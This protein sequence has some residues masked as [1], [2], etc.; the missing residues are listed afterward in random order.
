MEF[1]GMINSLNSEFS[2]ISKHSKFSENSIQFDRVVACQLEFSRIPNFSSSW[3]SKFLNSKFLNSKFLKFSRIPNSWNS[4]NSKFLEFFEQSSALSTTATG[5]TQHHQSHHVTKRHSAS[6]STAPQYL[7]Q[8]HQALT[9]T[10]PLR[11][12]SYCNPNLSLPACRFQAAATS[13]SLTFLLPRATVTA[14]LQVCTPTM[15][16][17]PAVTPPHTAR[18]CRVHAPRR[19]FMARLAASSQL[20]A[21][22]CCR[23]R[24]P[25]RRPVRDTACS[26]PSLPQKNMQQASARAACVVSG[27]F[28]AASQLLLRSHAHCDVPSL[29]LSRNWRAPSP[30]ALALLC[31]FV[32][33][34]EKRALPRHQ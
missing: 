26:R 2:R 17:C 16:Q 28:H 22:H 31:D 5:T 18:A 15:S 11:P 1:H 10:P 19:P 6:L 8:K 21:V 32:M 24:L 33:C 29:T 27:G 13:R 4:W 25:A 23:R 12:P 7:Q 34:E 9:R 30:G 3:N 14:V 20:P